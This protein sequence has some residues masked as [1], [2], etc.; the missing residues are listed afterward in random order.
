MFSFPAVSLSYE[1]SYRALCVCSRTST[2]ILSLASV[3]TICLRTTVEWCSNCGRRSCSRKSWMRPVSSVS[4]VLSCPANI[5]KLFTKKRSSASF[6]AC[7]LLMESTKKRQP[8]F[9]Y[10]TLVRISLNVRVG[11]RCISPS[12]SKLKIR[13]R[14]MPLSFVSLTCCR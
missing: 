13:S 14:R 6:A 7:S 3:I 5:F 8:R 2:V 4:I 1:V 12:L 11:T 9:C 10:L